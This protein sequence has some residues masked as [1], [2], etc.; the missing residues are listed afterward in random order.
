M[1]GSR[2]AGKGWESLSEVAD[3]D[4]RSVA[5]AGVASFFCRGSLMVMAAVLRSGCGWGLG[6]TFLGWE[7]VV[8]RGDLSLWLGKGFGPMT[9]LWGLFR[10]GPH[11]LC[12]GSS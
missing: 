7:V 12:A 5:D 8:F 3:V 10:S 11:P 4:E 9:P 1:E 2:S 6:L